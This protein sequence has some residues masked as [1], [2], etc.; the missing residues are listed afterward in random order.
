MYCVVEA[1]NSHQL[2]QTQTVRS[3]LHPVWNE[4]YQVACGGECVHA[5][6]PSAEADLMDVHVMAYRLK[7]PIQRSR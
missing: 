1:T 7:L 4:S 5:L 2:Y 6:L 3:S